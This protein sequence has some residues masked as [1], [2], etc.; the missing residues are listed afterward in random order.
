MPEGVNRKA[1]DRCHKQKLSCNRVG[2]EACERCIRGRTA[3]T[4]SPSLRYK[5]GKRQEALKL[6]TSAG[7]AHAQSQ[8]RVDD[9]GERHMVRQQSMPQLNHRYHR[10]AQQEHHPPAVSQPTGTQ[11]DMNSLGNNISL[12][13]G[14]TMPQTFLP[15]ADSIDQRGRRTPKRRRTAS[16]LGGAVQPEPGTLLC[17]PNSWP[18][19]LFVG[20]Y[21]CL[22][23]DFNRVQH[24]DSK[25]TPALSEK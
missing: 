6:P 5:K 3:C 7:S 19:L 24:G 11:F 14:I 20:I 21:P 16:E 18:I 17:F 8:R 23:L 12:E 2:E 1:C 9:E 13:P 22:I 15:D 10:H 4:S 25:L